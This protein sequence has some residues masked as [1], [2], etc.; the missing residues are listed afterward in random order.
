MRS[1]SGAT[2]VHTLSV[3]PSSLFCF[4]CEQHHLTSPAG[5]GVVQAAEKVSQPHSDE[6]Q[7]AGTDALRRGPDVPPPGAAL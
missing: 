6:H 3:L 4:V 5:S 7:A 1:D 2:G